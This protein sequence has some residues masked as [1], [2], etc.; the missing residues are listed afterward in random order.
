MK[1][2]LNTQTQL[3]VQIE[4]GGCTI[5]GYHS[6][7]A[8]CGGVD[9]ASDTALEFVV[10]G[11]EADSLSAN[12]LSTLTQAVAYAFNGVSSSD[13]HIESA[14]PTG[15]GGYLVRAVVTFRHSTTGYD[16]LSAEGIETILNNVQT[17]MFADG[18]RTIWAGLQ[19]TERSSV[20]HTATSVQYVSSSIVGSRDIPFTTTSV[21]EV[22]NFADASTVSYNE[23]SSSTSSI[24]EMVSY[25]GYAVAG[26]VAALIVGFF[27]SGRKR[28]ESE[29]PVVTAVAVPTQ[30]A[31]MDTSSNKRVQLKDLN[32]NA[33]S[34]SDLKQLV[35]D[36]D[37]VLKI[38]LSRP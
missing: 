25:A 9:G 38:M 31:T 27:V 18:P 32:L 24:P 16:T 3:T 15:S 21:D 10:M 29:V 28:V 30:D 8:L 23:K 12:D 7:T 14:T 26:V 13:V 34:L 2:N 17:F 1:N 33:P 37:E 19:A 35:K 6:S 5:L 22:A 4:D 20:F 11:V 36:E